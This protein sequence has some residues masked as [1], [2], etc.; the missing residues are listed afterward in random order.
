MAPL[1]M[2]PF[3]N[4]GHADALSITLS[5]N[6]KPFIVDPG[7]YRYNGVPR[8]RRYFKGTR[9]HNTVTIDDQDQAI[10]ETSFIWSHPYEAR[11]TAYQEENGDI[12]YHAVH[13]GYTAIDGTRQASAV[14]FVF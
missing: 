12:F 2:A 4:H 1:G 7:T 9:A 13:D 14:G 8:W 3:Y 5:K 6:G 10:Q 11:L